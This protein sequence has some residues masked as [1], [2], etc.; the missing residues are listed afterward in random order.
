MSRLKAIWRRIQS[1]WRSSRLRDEIAEEMAFHME[2]RRAENIR[3]GMTP[4]GK[5]PGSASAR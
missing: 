5:K 1:L 4:P 3:R 2:Q